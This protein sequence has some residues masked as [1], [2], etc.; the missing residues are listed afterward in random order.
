MLSPLLKPYTGIG[1]EQFIKLEN[2]TN[3]VYD[4]NWDKDM[5]FRGSKEIINK[6]WKLP[7]L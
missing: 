3:V 2:E 1:F 7:L 6:I 4:A 5:K